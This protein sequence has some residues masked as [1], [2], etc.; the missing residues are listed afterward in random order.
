VNKVTCN[1]A[2]AVLPVGNG[3]GCINEVT[4]HQAHLVLRWVTIYTLT[5][6]SD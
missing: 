3:I 4:L 1:E 5:T 6:G 2:V